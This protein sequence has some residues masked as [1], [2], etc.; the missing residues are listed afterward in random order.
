LK[1]KVVVTATRGTELPFD[2]KDVPTIIWESQK[3]LKEDL[4][5]RIRSIVKSGVGGASAPLD[6]EIRRT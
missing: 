3:K 1:K 5:A 4:N 2:V 6:E